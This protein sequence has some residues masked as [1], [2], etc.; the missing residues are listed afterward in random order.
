LPIVKL[1]SLDEARLSGTVNVTVAAM[2]ASINS[3]GA[4]YAA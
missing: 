2:T 1:T 4:R 3:G